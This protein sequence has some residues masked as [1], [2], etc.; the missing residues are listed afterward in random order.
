[1]LPRYTGI[2]DL[3]QSMAVTGTSLQPVGHATREP[4]PE[5][6]TADTLVAKQE[7]AVPLVSHVLN[8]HTYWYLRVRRLKQNCC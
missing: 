3:A 1:M 5:G 4:L 7:G 2:W 8:P 6:P